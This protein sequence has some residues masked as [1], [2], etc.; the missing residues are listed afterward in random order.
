VCEKQE[1][2]GCSTIISE[3]SGYNRFGVKVTVYVVYWN[4]GGK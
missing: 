3:F 2:Y 1:S 4:K